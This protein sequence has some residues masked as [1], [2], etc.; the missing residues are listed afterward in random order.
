MRVGL[1]R[2]GRLERGRGRRVRRL[3]GRG[4]PVPPPRAAALLGVRRQ[5]HR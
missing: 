3:L 4:L 5:N 2:L 1:E